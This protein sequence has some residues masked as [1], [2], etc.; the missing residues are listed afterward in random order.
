MKYLKNVVNFDAKDYEILNQQFA[1]NIKK[2]NV[3][4]YDDKV[5]FSN[6][7]KL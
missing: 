5:A 6:I 7:V 4:K 3:N 1:T 2:P